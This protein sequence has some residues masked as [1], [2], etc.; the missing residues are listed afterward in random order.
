[1]YTEPGR[2]PEHVTGIELEDGVR[3]PTSPETTMTVSGS[4]SRRSRL[5]E[6]RKV[7][8]FLSPCPP[9]LCEMFAAEE[10]AIISGALNPAAAAWTSSGV[11]EEAQQHPINNFGDFCATAPFLNWILIT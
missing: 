5:K 11:R 3:D 10:P 4:V 2:L 6:R 8:V 9:E 7:I 1:M